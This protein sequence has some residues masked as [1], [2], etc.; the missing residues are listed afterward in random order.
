MWFNGQVKPRGRMEKHHAV[1]SDVTK[2]LDQW[3]QAVSVLIMKHSANVSR[4]GKRRLCGLR[5]RSLSS[6]GE[7]FITNVLLEVTAELLIKDTGTLL[8]AD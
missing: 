1:T 6:L 5:W 2:N 4:V 7:Q 8:V 3:S